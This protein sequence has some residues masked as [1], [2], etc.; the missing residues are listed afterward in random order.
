MRA[1]HAG[2]SARAVPML[3]VNRQRRK[4][5]QCRQA[6]SESDCH[7]HFL[8][9]S[10]LGTLFGTEHLANVETQ[11]EAKAVEIKSRAARVAGFQPPEFRRLKPH[12][13]IEPVFAGEATGA[14]DDTGRI[15]WGPLT[16]PRRRRTLLG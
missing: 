6:K 15:E 1:S 9:T 2:A 12:P 7:F 4:C 16:C 14:A 8:T 10:L 11:I 13:G 3:G 5:S